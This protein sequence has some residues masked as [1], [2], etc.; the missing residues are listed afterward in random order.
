MVAGSE[1]LSGYADGANRFHDDARHLRRS[2][3]L[4]SLSLSLSSLARLE[5]RRG[6]PPPTNRL[7]DRLAPSRGSGDIGVLLAPRP[8]I[9]MVEYQS[10]VRTRGNDADAVG[11]AATKPPEGNAA[12]RVF[13]TT[14]RAREQVR[15]PLFRDYRGL[16]AF[17]NRADRL[18]S[19]PDIESDSQ[20]RDTPE[21]SSSCRLLSATVRLESHGSRGC[22]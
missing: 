3:P 9:S 8:K 16:P 4:L 22:G 20:S 6:C 18:I 13:V 2:L 10:R 19:T 5:L 7:V 11:A 21:F 15:F 1:K 17:W 12:R 14:R